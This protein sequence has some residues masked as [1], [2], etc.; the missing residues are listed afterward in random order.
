MEKERENLYA[1]ISRDVLI[2]IGKKSKGVVSVD[3]IN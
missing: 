2:F 3:T 1:I